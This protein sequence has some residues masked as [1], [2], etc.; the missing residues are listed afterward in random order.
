MAEF[1]QGHLH[2]AVNIPIETLRTHFHLL[3][4]K[5][6]VIIACCNDGSRSWYAKNLLDANGYRRVYDA[7]NWKKLE[8]NINK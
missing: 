4:D 2:G 6:K 8:R 5:Q 3:L 1:Q 7:G